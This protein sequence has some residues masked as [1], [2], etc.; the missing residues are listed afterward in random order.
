MKAYLAP[1]ENIVF[2]LYVA[3][4]AMLFSTSADAEV[5]TRA[6][7]RHIAQ[8]S[9]KSFVGTCF[10]K[11]PW[12]YT[13]DGSCVPTVAP[14]ASASPVTTTNYTRYMLQPGR[15]VEL[16]DS[17]KEAVMVWDQLTV[18]ERVDIVLA[19]PRSVWKKCRET[20]SP[21][22]IIVIVGAQKGSGKRATLQ[23][24]VAGQSASF[25]W[26]TTSKLTFTEIGGP[27]KN[28]FVLLEV[29]SLTSICA[30]AS[31]D[32]FSAQD[33]E[34]QRLGEALGRKDAALIAEQVRSSALAISA[35]NTQ[36]QAL[37]SLA[38]LS[39]SHLATL[40][41]LT[42]AHR[43]QVAGLQRQIELLNKKISDLEALLI[44]GVPKN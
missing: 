4:A 27:K 6:L 3:T 33:A 32:A 16:E 19:E 25:S 9:E 18:T 2:S 36:K 14:K 42:D 26:P 5:L 35:E 29:K 38:L 20:T 44:H 30:S 7:G 39:D 40:K 11:T 22:D 41:T 28:N 15:V 1:K 17:N 43:E 34:I 8:D 23:V 24:K 21:E 37:A 13:E 12:G 10:R 31:N